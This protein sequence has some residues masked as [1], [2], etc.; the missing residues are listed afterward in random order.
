MLDRTYRAISRV[1]PPIYLLCFLL[2]IPAF[3]AIYTYAPGQAFYA[4]YAKFEP[5]AAEDAFAFQQHLIAS[6]ARRVHEAPGGGGHWIILP[7][8]DVIVKP[9]PSPDE[10]TVTPIVNLTRKSDRGREDYRQVP[11]PVTVAF[12]EALVT[13]DPP[14]VCRPVEP[15]KPDALLGSDEAVIFHTLF[16][17]DGACS[18]GDF[19]VFDREAERHFNDLLLGW[20][21]DASRFSGQFGRSL[22]LSAITITTVGFGDIVPISDWSRLAV[23]LEAVMGIVL[24]GLFLNAVGWRIARTEPGQAIR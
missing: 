4:P 7:E 19:L 15:P 10:L 12:R 6:F 16:H 22:Y 5:Q 23:A 9:G 17:G 13:G 21:G 18:E 14:Q 1:S 20:M 24:S 2:L 11:L 3:A 8:F